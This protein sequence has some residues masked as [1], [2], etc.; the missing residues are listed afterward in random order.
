MHMG[1]LLLRVVL[2]VLWVWVGLMRVRLMGLLRLRRLLVLGESA[3]GQ[4]GSVGA[5]MVPAHLMRHVCL[6]SS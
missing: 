1:V 5:P 4:R 3:K 2:L 6:S